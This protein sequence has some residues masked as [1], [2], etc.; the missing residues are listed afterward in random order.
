[1]S[2]INET[3]NFTHAQNAKVDLY[4]LLVVRHG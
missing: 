2:G 3:A 4:T 1:M